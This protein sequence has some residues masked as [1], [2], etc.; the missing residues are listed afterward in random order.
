MQFPQGHQRTDLSPPGSACPLLGKIYHSTHRPRVSYGGWPARRI[1]YGKLPVETLGCLARG[2]LRSP[3]KW[4]AEAHP[5][6]ERH[7]LVLASVTI[8]DT[9]TTFRKNY[10]DLDATYVIKSARSVI[11]SANLDVATLSRPLLGKRRTAD[12]A[13]PWHCCGGS[14]VRYTAS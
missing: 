5:T 11:S 12:T 1:T 9:G 3:R 13:R 7:R 10:A 2:G 4:S 14:G 8:I 6:T